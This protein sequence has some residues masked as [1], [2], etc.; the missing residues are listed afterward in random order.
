MFRR[1]K[2][3][4]ENQVDCKIKVFRSDNRTKYTL[5]KFRSFCEE[6]AIQHQLTIPYTAQQNRVDER[7]NHNVMEMAKCLLIEKKL[8]KNL[9][10]TVIN[11]VVYLF[12]RL[13]TKAFKDKTPFEAWFEVKLAMDHLRVFGCLCCFYV[14]EAKRE[15]LDQ[16]A[17]VGIFLGYSCNVKDYNVFNLKTEKKKKLWLLV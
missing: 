15:K 14:P 9:V 1:F 17:N 2:S 5:E 7:K 3:S 4:I 11:T 10:L 13:P 12:K 16:K 8:P 6:V